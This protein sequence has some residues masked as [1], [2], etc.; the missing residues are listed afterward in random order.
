LTLTPCWPNPVHDSTRIEFALPRS[1]TV[2]LRIYDVAGRCVRKL[3]AGSL[4]WGTRQLIWNGRDDGGRDVANGVYF[5][6]LEAGGEV[7]TRKLLLV[8]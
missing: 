2:T 1:G 3:F 4:P 7:R 6:R 8:R 5:Y